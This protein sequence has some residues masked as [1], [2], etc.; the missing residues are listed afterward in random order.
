MMNAIM[1]IVNI[2]KIAYMVVRG[3][4]VYSVS[5]FILFGVPLLFWEKTVGF[6]Q[7]EQVVTVWVLWYVWL[8]VLM[9]PLWYVSWSNMAMLL[10]TILAVYERITRRRVSWR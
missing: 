5:L 4:Y 7:F 2:A 1:K 6:M 8:F 3:I 10:D 9:R